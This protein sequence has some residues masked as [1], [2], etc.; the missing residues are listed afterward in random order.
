LFVTPIEP[1]GIKRDGWTEPALLR[2]GCSGNFFTLHV[3]LR[4]S[5]TDQLQRRG[6]LQARIVIQ[7]LRIARDSLSK[8]FIAGKERTQEEKA[9]PLGFGF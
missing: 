3:C 8:Q 7:I 6:R 1:K 4:N 2:P 9:L 5:S